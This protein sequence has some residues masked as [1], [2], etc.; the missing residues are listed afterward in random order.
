MFS[1]ADKELKNMFFSVIV[2]IYK[3]EKYLVRCIEGVL[4]QTFSDFELILVDD[5]SPDNCPAICDEYAKKDNRITVIHKENG[6]LVSARQAGIKIAKGEYVFHLDADDGVEKDALESAF[7]IISKTNADIV[8]FSY[9]NY[10]NGQVS[11]PV[12]D[13]LDEGLYNRKDIEEHIF[14]KLLADKN[15]QHSLYFLWGRAIKRSLATENQLNVSTEI[16][17]GEDLVCIVP[18]MLQAQKVYVSHKPIYLY[19]VRDESMSKSFN[20]RQITLISSVVEFLRELE[21]PQNIDFD[22]QIARY[23]FFMSFAILAAAAEG[24]HFDAIEEL[25]KLILNSELNSGIQKAEF[26]WLTKKSRIALF[27]MKKQKFKFTFYFLYVC[28]EIKRVFRGK[29]G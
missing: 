10:K 23:S 27:L 20:T 9:R 11:E 24:N 28:K 14:P 16:S 7:E 13:V 18:C 1:G 15:M 21:V 25:K 3:V 26:N 19:T 8:S 17:L 2:P 22:G 4:S 29:R 6:G 5:G 12:N